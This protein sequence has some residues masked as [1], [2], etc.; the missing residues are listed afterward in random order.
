MCFFSSFH[1]TNVKYYRKSLV[2]T[3]F[4]YYFALDFKN[5]Q[6]C[7]VLRNNKDFNNIFNKLIFRET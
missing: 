6:M 5:V 1:G 4:F 2:V 7:N 3:F